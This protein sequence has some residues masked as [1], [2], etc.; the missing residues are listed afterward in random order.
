MRNDKRT[1]K[2]RQQII[3]S[4]VFLSDI[5]VIIQ[6]LADMVCNKKERVII[7]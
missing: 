7:N 2:I 3:F 5:A 4:K 6:F 1:E